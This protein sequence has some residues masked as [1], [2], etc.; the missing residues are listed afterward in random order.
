MG[1]NCGGGLMV[2]VYACQALLGYGDDQEAA[3]FTDISYKAF[4]S[5]LHIRAL[6]DITT[7]NPNLKKKYN[8]PYLNTTHIFPASIIL[9]PWHIQLPGEAVKRQPA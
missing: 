4:E 5:L 8:Y 6:D 2:L 3:V 7:Y 1:L 9:K